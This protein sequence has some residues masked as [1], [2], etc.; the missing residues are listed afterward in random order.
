MSETNWSDEDIIKAFTKVVLVDGT[1]GPEEIMFVM[2]GMRDQLVGQIDD[3]KLQLAESQMNTARM[4]GA[5]SYWEFQTKKLEDEQKLTT[6]LDNWTASWELAGKKVS[7]T[8]HR[9]NLGGWYGRAWV[10]DDNEAMHLL[11]TAIHPDIESVIREMNSLA[12]D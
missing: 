5:S 1:V 9:V 2:K 3:L 12:E 11:D 10:Q 4:F 8:L 7:L 6:H